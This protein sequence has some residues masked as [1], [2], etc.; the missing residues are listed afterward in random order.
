[1]NERRCADARAA[2]QGTVKC[3]C[4][5]DRVECFSSFTVEISEY[6]AVRALPDRFILARGHDMPGEAVVIDAAEYLV[7]DKGRHNEDS[8]RVA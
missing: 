5:C 8:A 7:V 1:M 2:G 3:E 4:E 6:Q